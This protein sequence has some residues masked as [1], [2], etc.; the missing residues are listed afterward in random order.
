MH[1]LPREVVK[2]LQSLDLSFPIKNPKRDFANG[3]LMA[4]IFSRYYPGQIQVW[5]LYTGDSTAQK[6]NNWV[7]FRR[8]GINVPREAMDAV[9]HCHADA[10]VRFVEN[11]YMLVTSRSVPARAAAAAADEIVPHFALPTTANVIRSMAPTADKA[12]VVLAAHNEFLAELR[13]ACTSG[14]CSTNILWDNLNASNVRIEAR[15]WI[16]YVRVNELFADAILAIYQ[17]GD[18]VWI[19]DYHLLLLPSL[20]RRALPHAT[21]GFFLHTPFPSSEIFRCLPRRKEILA[22]VLG[23]N[24]VGFQTYAHARHFISSCTRVLGCESS[25]TG[26]EFQGFNVSIGIFP[27]GIDLE[28]IERLRTSEGVQQKIKLIRELFPGK[29]I[30]IG[31]DK[32][33]QIKGI[34]HKL[35]AFEKF[36]QMYP[37]WHN[38]VALVQVTS[39][40][41]RLVRSFASK[42]SETVSR[43]NGT[44]GSL[45]YVPVN[46]YHQVLDEEEYYALLTLADA[47]LI[48]SLRDGMNTSSHEYVVCQ[49]DNY[50]SLILSEFTGTA[51]SMSGAHLINPWDHVGVASAINEA[52]LLSHEDRRLKHKQLLDYVT[53]HT[54]QFWAESFIRELRATALIPDQQNPTPFID[55]PLIIDRYQSSKKRLLLFDYDGTLTPIRKVPNAAVPP[56]DMLRAMETLVRDP[57]NVIFVISGRDQ[58]CLD[59]WLGHI[60][61]LGLSAEHGSFIKYPGGKWINLAAEI[62]LSWKEKVVEIFNYFTE[63]TQGSFVEHKHYAV[64][65]H[66]RLADPDYGIFQAKECQVHLENAILSKLPVEILIG[67]KNLEVRPISMNKGEIVKRLIQSRLP[68][69]DFVYCVGDDRTD[70]DMFKALRKSDL[71]EDTYFTCTIGSA[72]KKTH[73]QWHVTSTQNVINLMAEFAR[74]SVAMGTPESSPTDALASP[75]SLD[76]RPVP[77][78]KDAAA[79]AADLDDLDDER[80]EPPSAELDI[81]GQAPVEN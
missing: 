75:A 21:I 20:L 69:C 56:P 47:A 2:W 33:D 12:R 37:Q 24:L 81:D 72:T 44:Y 19:H 41:Q 30:I 23:A 29:K 50:G 14:R 52:L 35:N 58:D 53:S 61:N 11:I 8:N 64:T 65:W 32:L 28:R 40:P 74:I 49:Q 68:G 73:A 26:V 51:G 57:R 17:P 31:R 10:A 62:D 54:A 45:E 63:R 38:K 3:Y 25:P 67:K 43:I 15:N 46:Y 76:G 7:V 60:P 34:Q 80:E 77:D 59:D 18:I 6:A 55:V 5:L 71:P 9:M 16:D 39:P 36:L 22:G 27:I 70:E 78:N 66:Y 1:G 48:T 13:G 79:A 42:I 4:E